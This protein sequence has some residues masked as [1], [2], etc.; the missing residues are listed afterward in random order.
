M[1]AGKCDSDETCVDKWREKRPDRDK[2]AILQQFP[3]TKQECFST[4]IWI[5]RLLNH[6]WNLP[7]IIRRW[8]S[9]KWG[10]PKSTKKFLQTLERMLPSSRVDLLL[11][12][13]LM[14]PQF[15]PTAIFY[16]DEF[17]QD[18]ETS[19]LL[20]FVSFP[21][22]RDG[23]RRRRRRQRQVLAGDRIFRMIRFFLDLSVIRFGF[24]RF[25]HSL[26]TT[27]RPLW[28][29]TEASCRVM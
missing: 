28:G 23:G 12:V 16:D 9:N 24:L 10:L 7:A 2:S 13:F 22:L 11:L 3:A 21:V 15:R 17:F 5:S 26:E 20:I 4:P 19:N 14:P 25:R 29:C 8:T 27:K 6:R 1:N 18:K